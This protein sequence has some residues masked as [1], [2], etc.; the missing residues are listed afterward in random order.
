MSHL[1]AEEVVD[2]V[3]GRMN[4]PR[5]DHLAHCAR[6]R[7]RV[8]RLASTLHDVAGDQMPEPSPL[9]WDRL[10]ARVRDAI[11]GVEPD[12]A[13]SPFSW[14]ADWR[15]RAP[16][17]GA[18]ALVAAFVLFVRPQVVEDGSTGR[19]EVRVVQ[20]DQRVGDDGWG[21][22]ADLVATMDWDE[23]AE[24]GLGPTPGATDLVVLDLSEDERAELYRLLQA[25]L[26]RPRS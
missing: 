11:E 4:A 24:A 23:A 15:F 21:V 18:A 1:T 17:A 19:P 9:F 25:E 8:E 10:S 3:D 7:E 16:V 20:P 2:A 26:K 6:C 5:R 12:H 13:R 22:V 14:L